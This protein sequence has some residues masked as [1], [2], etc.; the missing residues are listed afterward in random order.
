MESN[1]L[2]AT[3]RLKAAQS[4]QSFPKKTKISDKCQQVFADWEELKKKMDHSKKAITLAELIKQSCVTPLSPK[5]RSQVSRLVFKPSATHSKKPADD[6]LES[7]VNKLKTFQQHLNKAI[8][9]DARPRLG[10]KEF[11]PRE[12]PSY[13]FSPRHSLA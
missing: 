10:T 12:T 5:N 8:R 4:A 2:L 11:K 3:C 1:R 13:P 7:L 9:K 6:G